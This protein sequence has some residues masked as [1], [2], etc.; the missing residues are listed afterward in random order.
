MEGMVSKAMSATD[1][2]TQQRTRE[3][4]MERLIGRVD[5]LIERAGRISERI[6][7]WRLAIFVAGVVCS[8]IPYK[9]QWYHLANAA[10]GSFLVVF[11][12]V[13][14]YHSKLETRM[15]RLRLWRGIKHTP[16]ARLRL[17]WHASH[18]LARPSLD[19]HSF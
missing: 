1:L 14:H 5:R 16:L 17:D 12:I 19:S 7:R 3:Q 13:A 10:V 15:H 6:T 11:L 2:P 18:A 8:V 4:T 9:L